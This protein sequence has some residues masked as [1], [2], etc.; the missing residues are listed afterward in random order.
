M[1]KKHIIIKSILTVFMFIIA[2]I[3]IYP[4]I[5]MFAGSFKPLNEIYIYPPQLWSENATLKNYQEVL[6]EQT[7]PFWKYGLNTFIVTIVSVIGTVIT[8]SLGG[9]AFAKMKFKGRDMLFIFY[10]ATMMIPFQ[11]LMVPQFLLFKVLGIFNTLWALILPR[12]FSPLA[13]FLMRQYFTGVPNEII[14]SGRIDGASEFKIFRSLVFPLAKPAVATVSILNF[15]WRWNDY[16]APLIFISDKNL[17]TLTV[18]LTNFIDDS[19]FALENM[20]MAGTTIATIP[21]LIIYILGQ[22]YIIEGMTSGSVKG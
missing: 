18:G 19:G 5:M 14:E 21:I 17:Y 22:K 9:Y 6:F 8:A 4:F 13:T 10:L 7:P 12:I 2:L 1:Q 3:V 16:E 11:A 15:V 20:V